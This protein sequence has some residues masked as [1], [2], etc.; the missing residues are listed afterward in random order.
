MKSLKRFGRVQSL[1]SMVALSV[2][3]FVSPA[4]TT[5]S[6]GPKQIKKSIPT[7]ESVEKL[8]NVPLAPVLPSVESNQSARGDVGSIELNV[9]TAPGATPSVS[10][11]TYGTDLTVK[12][13]FG[14]RFTVT[15]A[16]APFALAI[17][18]GLFTSTTDGTGFEAGQEVGITIFVD[19]AS[20]G[21]INN[22]IP[23]FN[24]TATLDQVDALIGFALPEPII[25]RQGDIYI[26]FTDRSSDNE[27]TAIPVIQGDD[28]GVT[29]PRSF[30]S[31]NVGLAPN[32]LNQGGYFPLTDSQIVGNTVV[33][34]FGD[35]ATAG[36]VVTSND[37]PTDNTLPAPSNL[38]ATGSSPVI[39]SW[40][41]P[42]L[43]PPPAPTEVAEVEPNDSPETAQQIGTNDRVSGADRSTNNGS[44]GGF[45]EDAEDWYAITLNN[46]TSIN[47]DLTGFGGADFDMLLYPIG[48]PFSS[49]QAIAVSGNAAGEDENISLPLLAAGTYVIA[50]S[51]FDPDVPNNT[52]YMLTVVAA[53]KVNRYNIFA[54]SFEGFVPSAENF[55]G[56][57]AGN[58]TS[59]TVRE[60]AANAFYKVSAVVGGSQSAG[61]NGATGSPCEGGP[62]IT[63]VKVKRNGSGKITLKG[64]GFTGNVQILIN[65]VGFASAPK[66]KATK[67]NQKG[68][69]ANGQT[70]GQACPSGCSLTI[71]NGDGGCTAATAP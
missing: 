64:S 3:L 22:A 60:S 47:I 20:T 55:V 25:V 29:D 21:D 42:N 8:G 32:P 36:S 65:G 31:L 50:I 49:D 28:G 2:G 23:V 54:G 7:L 1:L 5:V 69:L 51:A 6:A 4:H 35:P 33:R 9:D 68:P 57:A 66:V 26:I 27:D 19:A 53:P 67:V 56:N 44:P 61:S 38:T 34:G 59:F 30:A 39:L 15:D 11:F 18:A 71:I 41:A 48:G 52:N 16:Q 62:T 58:A 10:I 24:G 63:S 46:P 43:P 37:E 17:V 45:G 70:V 12:A 13:C 40:T 14:N